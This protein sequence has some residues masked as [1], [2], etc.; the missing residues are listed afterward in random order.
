MIRRARSK[1]NSDSRFITVNL[2][3]G[4]GSGTNDSDVIFSH[5][6]DDNENIS[7]FCFADRPFSFFSI[8]MFKVEGEYQIR[9]AKDGDGFFKT[10]SVFPEI[11][12]SLVG[13]PV[14]RHV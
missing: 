5:G 11:G 6:E 14:K 13:I 4:S 1:G 2:L 7:I 8:G 12:L 3:L 9:I 10:N